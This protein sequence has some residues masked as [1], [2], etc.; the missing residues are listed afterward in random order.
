MV[1][2]SGQ[3]FCS[4]ASGRMQAAGRSELTIHAHDK[5]AGIGNVRQLVVRPAL[6]RPDIICGHRV[7]RRGLRL[8]QELL[9]AECGSYS[10]EAAVLVDGAPSAACSSLPTTAIIM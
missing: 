1:L 4:R 10:D 3:C 8:V 9:A 5:T 6:H 2:F 7:R